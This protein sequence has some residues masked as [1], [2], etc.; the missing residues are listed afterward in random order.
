MTKLNLKLI[1]LDYNFLVN[2]NKRIFMRE[3]ELYLSYLIVFID[4][5]NVFPVFLRIYLLMSFH[6][7][8]LY[9]NPQLCSHSN[10]HLY[11]GIPEIFHSKYFQIIK[12]V[13]TVSIGFFIIQ[14]YI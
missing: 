13:Y 5:L 1:M 11:I 7:L 3:H 8:L 2:I 9:A 12:K 6:I 10:Q 4:Y 14:L